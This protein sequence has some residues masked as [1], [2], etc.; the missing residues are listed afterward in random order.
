MSRP[1][2]RSISRRAVTCQQL[3]TRRHS[4]RQIQRATQWGGI[5]R[6]QGTGIGPAAPP[7]THCGN[8]QGRSN[9]N[10]SSDGGSGLLEH[11]PS[12]RMEVFQLRPPC[13]DRKFCGV[14]AIQAVPVRPVW[15]PARFLK[16]TVQCR[17]VAGRPLSSPVVSNDGPGFSSWLA[18]CAIVPHAPS[19][20]RACVLAARNLHRQTRRIVA[21]FVS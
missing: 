20:T 21:C 7:H 9:W 17:N 5:S 2:L 15:E 1:R 14:E 11:F 19:T 8:F 12:V 3:R 13:A 10:G 16:K 18:A 6:S 4:Q